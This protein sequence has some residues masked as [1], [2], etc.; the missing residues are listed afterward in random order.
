MKT[1][2]MPLM[3]LLDP[4]A[5]LRLLLLPEVASPPQTRTQQCMTETMTM[6]WTQSQRVR[7]RVP[8][9]CGSGTLAAEGGGRR[10]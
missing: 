2:T 7:R 3:T 4:L 1:V 9:A 6:T 8:R 5:R 10:G